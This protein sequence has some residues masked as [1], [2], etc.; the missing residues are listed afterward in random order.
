MFLRCGWINDGSAHVTAKLTRES[1]DRRRRT[2]GVGFHEL[3]RLVTNGGDGQ[4]VL[5]RISEFDVA[6][7]ADSLLHDSSHAFT[8][9]PAI[10]VGQLTAMPLPTCLDHSGL[11]LS[12]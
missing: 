7:A 11:T 12:R 5:F 3:S 10:P 4:I 2:G 8:A 6:N 1:I 9:L